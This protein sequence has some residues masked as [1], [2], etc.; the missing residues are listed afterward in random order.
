MSLPFLETKDTFGSYTTRHYCP[1]DGNYHLSYRGT[2]KKHS[3]QC[4][5]FDSMAN[6]C[7]SGST[8]NFMLRNCTFEGYGKILLF[9]CPF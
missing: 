9:V 2:A 5:G 4:K 6:S 1:I 8:L 3:N 7:P